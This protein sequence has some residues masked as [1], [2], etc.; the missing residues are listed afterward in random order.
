MGEMRLHAQIAEGHLLQMITKTAMLEMDFA[1]NAHQNIKR[2][3]IDRW[4]HHRV[5]L[6]LYP[7]TNE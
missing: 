2:E 3:K 6:F 5:A 4:S 7:K 1:V